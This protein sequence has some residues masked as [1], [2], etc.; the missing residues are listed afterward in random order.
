[1][2]NNCYI[3]YANSLNISYFTIGSF[4]PFLSHIFSTLSETLKILTKLIPNSP[5]LAFIEANAL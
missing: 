5:F 1:M 2:K 3:D 4:M